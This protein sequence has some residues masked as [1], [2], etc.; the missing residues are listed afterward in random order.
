MIFRVLNG[1][2]TIVF[3][4][5]PGFIGN[6]NNNTITGT[7]VREL[8][9]G[10]G[11]NDTLNGGGGNDVLHGGAG[12]D[13]IIGGAGSDTVLYAGA[14][15]HYDARILND[16]SIEL[17]DTLPNS[18]GDCGTDILTGIEKIRFLSSGT[19][20]VVT[21]TGGNDNLTSTQH[22]F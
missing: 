19:Y 22:W 11:G 9:M 1:P 13:H 12:N 8:L 15:T 6:D 3:K 14:S 2:K 16:G 21:G 10:K 5:I 18:Y 4:G 20:D 17:R 7:A